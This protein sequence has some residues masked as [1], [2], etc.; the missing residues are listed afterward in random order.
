MP[1]SSIITTGF[2]GRYME[3][4]WAAI[5]AHARGQADAFAKMEKAAAYLKRIGPRVYQWMDTPFWLR[6]PEALLAQWKEEDEKL[7]V[8]A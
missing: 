4:V 5:D 1:S 2:T 6:T 8:K 3:L 7:L